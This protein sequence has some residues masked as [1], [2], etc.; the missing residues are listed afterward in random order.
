M[1]ASKHQPLV[2]P[3]MT[4]PIV[5]TVLRFQVTLYNVKQL[6]KCINKFCPQE[7]DYQP[8]SAHQG[9]LSEGGQTRADASR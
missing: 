2:H 5:H 7:P 1:T 3:Q 4:L 6:S 8:L 9:T